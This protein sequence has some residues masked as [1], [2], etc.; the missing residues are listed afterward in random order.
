MHYL[1]VAVT[2]ASKSP[3]HAI[4]RPYTIFPELALNLELCPPKL[5]KHQDFLKQFSLPDFKPFMRHFG[6]FLN[7]FL[8]NICKS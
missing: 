5:E 8:L 6:Y 2:K 7:I 4:M 1:F 3:G